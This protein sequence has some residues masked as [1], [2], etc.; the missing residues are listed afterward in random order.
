MTD[1]ELR[2]F[3]EQIR[4]YGMR[5]IASAGSGHIGGMFSMAEL[6]AVLY[7]V[8]LRIDPANPKKPDRDKVV[9]S[10]GHC[11]PGLQA[12]LALKGFF[13]MDWLLTVNQNGTRL[14]SHCDMNKTPGIDMTTGSLGQGASIAAGLA[15]GDKTAKRVFNTYL[16]LG[17]GELDEGQVWEMALFAAQ[18]KLGNLVACI[19]ANA[20]QLDG[21]T[22]D[23]ASL[24]D[25]CAKFAAFGWDAVTVTGMTWQL[26]EKRS[27]TLCPSLTF[28]QPL[29]CRQSKAKGGAR[30]KAAFLR[31]TAQSV[32]N[33]RQ[34]S[35]LKSLRA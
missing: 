3:A 9:L 6:L 31:I 17:D 13:P 28:L 1:N 29:F 25:I 32:P 35:S 11:G 14:P 23:I 5:A 24:G 4:L 15:L 20:Q 10:K 21:Y 30:W 33:R 12:V 22:K 34:L 2:L 8:Y 19:D 27:P 26:S 18:Q 7:G 16:I